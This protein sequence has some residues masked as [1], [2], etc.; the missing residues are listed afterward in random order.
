MLPLCVDGPLL[1]TGV[2][3]ANTCSLAL[4]NVLRPRCLVITLMWPDVPSTGLV[5][6]LP[7][8]LPLIAMVAIRVPKQ[9]LLIIL[10]CISYIVVLIVC[11]PLLC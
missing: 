8:V 4:P 1:A 9:L 6:T 3:N 2:L 10:M 7:P 5:N 11:P